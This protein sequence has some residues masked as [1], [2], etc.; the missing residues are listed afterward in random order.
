MPVKAKVA[1]LDVNEKN[2]FVVA[3]KFHMRPFEFRVELEIMT[4]ALSM[5]MLSGAVEFVKASSVLTGTLSWLQTSAMLRG[6]VDSI[7]VEGAELVVDV[8]GGRF[9]TVSKTH[10]EVGGME[11][12]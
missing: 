3:N 7:R 4:R 12:E 9:S 10:F 5:S 11:R 6:T 8:P 2:D 1:L